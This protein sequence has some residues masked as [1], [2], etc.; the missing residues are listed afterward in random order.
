MSSCRCCRMTTEVVVGRGEEGRKG[1]MHTL[2]GRPQS[3]LQVARRLAAAALRLSE[4]ISSSG[5]RSKTS[6]L[7]SSSRERGKEMKV[8]TSLSTMAI[9][10]QKEQSTRLRLHRRNIEQ[11]RSVLFVSTVLYLLFLFSH[12]H[13]WR[14]LSFFLTTL[15]SRCH[16]DYIK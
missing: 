16:Y 8:A 12:S 9:G 1:Q 5:G 3:S 2:F 13:I 6:F 11:W 7:F 14:V 15:D 10:L 4:A